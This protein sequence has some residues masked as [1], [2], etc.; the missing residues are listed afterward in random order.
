[1]RIQII[2]RESSVAAADQ[3]CSQKTSCG[4]LASGALADD[5]EEAQR[6]HKTG[7]PFLQSYLPFW[8]ATLTGRLI[9]V[10]IPLAALLY[11]VFKLVPLMYDWIMRSKV[12]RLYNEMRSIEREIEARGQG[13][14]AAA[15]NAKLD[16]LDQRANHLKLPAA[17]ASMSYMLRAH[18]DLVRERLAVSP[19]RKL[20]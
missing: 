13:H 7:R 1:M 20:D 17:Y 16:E 15:M 4:R 9:V 8:M 12:M 18:I 10:L 2:T 14:D 19:G 6:F 11:P 5:D 3:D